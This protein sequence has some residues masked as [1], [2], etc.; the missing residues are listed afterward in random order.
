[1]NLTETD[2]E[3]AKL[4]NRQLNHPTPKSEKRDMLYTKFRIEGAS[5]IA[6]EYYK[7]TKNQIVFEKIKARIPPQIK[8]MIKKV[9]KRT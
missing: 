5:T 8:N 3:Q 4:Y 9:L 7:E 2:F 1:M 6:N